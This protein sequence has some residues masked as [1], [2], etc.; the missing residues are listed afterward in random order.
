MGVKDI[1][2]EDLVFSVLP[3]ENFILVANPFFANLAWYRG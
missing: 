2:P 1:F 3:G